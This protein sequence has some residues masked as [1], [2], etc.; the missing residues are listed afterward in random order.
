MMRTK[1]EFIFRR[2]SV[3]WSSGDFLGRKQAC[4]GIEFDRL[5]SW[6]P[7]DPLKALD[8]LTSLRKSQL[9]VR[10]READKGV[11]ATFMVDN[12]PSMRFASHWRSKLE[13]SQAC[14]RLFAKSLDGS[15]NIIRGFL[16]SAGG[17]APF[18]PL[19]NNGVKASDCS[20]GGLNELLV[21]GLR[22]DNRPNFL[23]LFSDFLGEIDEPLFR[24]ILKLH[25]V[26]PV[27]VA[28]LVEQDYGLGL[29]LCWF[30]DVETGEVFLGSGVKK[31]GAISVLDRAYV[32]F[33]SL[34]TSFGEREII[35]ETK[36]FLRSRRA[37][38]KERRVRAQ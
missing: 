30:R 3:L 28:D 35:Q 14:A 2:L 25:D 34:K 12:S 11:V 7:G 6:S 19:T 22:L 8:V 1:F 10:M 15:G 5:R 31:G 21:H 32:P 24:R 33:I 13:L 36:R 23:F 20:G 4:E 18:D 9:Y 17:L 38:Q 16:S 26:I 27:A 29:G 37:S